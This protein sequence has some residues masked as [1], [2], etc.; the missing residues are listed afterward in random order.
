MRGTSFSVIYKIEVRFIKIG[1]INNQLYK[2][3]QFKA[4][5]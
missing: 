5:F 2:P 4:T 3:G 1:E